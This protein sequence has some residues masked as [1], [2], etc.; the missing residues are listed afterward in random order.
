M[1]ATHAGRTFDHL[2]RFDPASLEYRIGAVAGTELP[3]TGRVWK[4]NAVLDQGAEGACV[5]MGLAGEAAAEPVPVP[6]VT[7]AY[8]RGWYRNAQRRDT[9]PGEAYSGTS[10]LAGLLE[11]RARGLYTG[12]LWAKSAAELAAG[13]V[14]PK[15]RGGGPAVIGVEWTQGSYNTNVLGVLRPGGPVVGGHCVCVLGFLPV[16]VAADSALGRQ[17]HGLGLLAGYLSLEGPCFVI[18]N[19]W[20]RSFGI[21]GLALVPLDVM[22]AWVDAR[23]EFAQPV[24]RSLPAAVRRGAAM[25]EPGQDEDV[26]PERDED[27]DEDPDGEPDPEPDDGEHP[28]TTTLHLTAADVEDRDR[29]LDPPE[30]LGQESVTARGWPQRVSGRRVRVRTS[31]GTFTISAGAPVT[32]RRPQ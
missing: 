19:S 25:T 7:N 10:V 9:W 24:G 11:G 31:A 6:G 26:E 22:Q 14:L 16:G 23:G 2:P 5:G 30:E 12:F 4:H 32:V 17:L 13:I 18:V 21:D 20:G 8:A 1:A 29:I 27:V 3:T 28:G 15:S